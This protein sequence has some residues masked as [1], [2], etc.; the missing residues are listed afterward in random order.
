MRR[1][2]CLDVSLSADLVSLVTCCCP[3]Q[4][5]PSVLG[6]LSVSPCTVEERVHSCS[7]YLC[8]RQLSVLHHTHPSFLFEADFCLNLQFPLWKHRGA[9]RN[10]WKVESEDVGGRCGFPTWRQSKDHLWVM[11]STKDAVGKEIFSGVQLVKVFSI[12]S[13]TL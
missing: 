3:A 10:R 2:P 13:M 5:V 11:C 6:L 9:Q 8:F 12:C 7:C 4:A 1:L